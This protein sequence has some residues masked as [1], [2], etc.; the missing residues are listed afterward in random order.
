MKYV[1]MIN[2]LFCKQLEEAERL[3]VYGQN[4]DAG[5]CLS[6]LTRGFSG[7]PDVKVL[8]TQNSENALLGAG[9]GLMLRGFN[10]AFFMKQQD[11]LLLGCDQIVNTWNILRNKNLSTSFTI[12]TIVVDHGFEGPQSQLNNFSDFCSLAHIPGFTLNSEAEAKYIISKEFVKPGFRIFGV[13]Q[14]LFGGPVPGLGF[15][16]VAL[17]D[18]EIF[19]YEKG[20]DL[21]IVSTNFAFEQSFNFWQRCK[22]QGY[23]VSL[24]SVPSVSPSSWDTIIEDACLTKKILVID[25]SKTDNKPIHRL[26]YEVL[27]SNPDINCQIA[28]RQL[29]AESLYPNDDIFEIN[30][31]ETIGGFPF[32]N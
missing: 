9:F 8:N 4:I 10:A 24:F 6:G 15:S 21:T 3:A 2:S 14:R 1:S 31:E 23:S 19:C 22:K 16:P 29:G 18:G 5:S 32:D 28:A 12:V 26:L 27:R 20:T 30:F 17:Y 25:D 11:F 13:S 7:I